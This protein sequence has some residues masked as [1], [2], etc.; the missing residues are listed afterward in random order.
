M[1]PT[2]PQPTIIMP[3]KLLLRNALVVS[4]LGLLPGCVVSEQKFNNLQFNVRNQD[5]RLVNLENTLEQISSGGTTAAQTMLKRQASIADELERLSMEILQLKGQLDESR[6]H[7]RELQEE[8]RRLQQE[9][10]NKLLNLEALSQQNTA[11]IHELEAGITDIKATMAQEAEQRAQKAL[12]AAQ[13]AQARAAQ[14]AAATAVQATD[15]QTKEI[16]PA[17]HKK[18]KDADTPAPA[19]KAATAPKATSEP[20]TDK[21]PA[22]KLYDMGLGQYRSKDYKG[23]IATFNTFLDRHKGDRLLPDARFWLGSSLL[24]NGDYSGAVLEFQNIVADY[25]GH[26]KAPEALL[27]QAKAFEHFGDKMVQKKLYK[28]V[29]TYYPNTEQAIKAKQLLGKLQ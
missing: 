5:N 21:S 18:K 14:A 22:E 24:N 27:Q 26:A 15:S 3:K 29:L 23:A 8:N 4:L 10:D 11:A 17:L 20:A 28:D 1:Q 7:S 2:S 9:L 25:P 16:S 13:E 12:R 19:V 6:H